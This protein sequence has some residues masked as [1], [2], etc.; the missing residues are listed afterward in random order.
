[1]TYS[2]HYDQFAQIWQHMGRSSV[3]ERWWKQSKTERVPCS[4]T[5]WTS[6]SRC[7]HQWEGVDRS[8]S[9][10]QLTWWMCASSCGAPVDPQIFEHWGEFW[11]RAHQQKQKKKTRRTKKNPE[12][13][14]NSSNANICQSPCKQTEKPIWD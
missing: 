14:K 12:T 6:S 10:G 2:A 8:S 1:M 13:Y 11:S 5:R 7:L 9:P 4:S 3:V